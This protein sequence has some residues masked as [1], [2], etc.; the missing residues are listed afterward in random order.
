MCEFFLKRKKTK[1]DSVQ[2]TG[3]RQFNTA[4][5][6]HPQNP[7]D[8]LDIS[9]HPQSPQHVPHDAHSC[10]SWMRESFK[11]RL[12]SQLE[13]TKKKKKIKNC[14]LAPAA[15]VCVYLC[16]CVLND[17]HKC[18]RATKDCEPDIWS[19]VSPIINR[20]HPTCSKKTMSPW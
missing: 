11:S 4:A 19:G 15:E 6:T 10:L 17:Q 3:P 8:K 2:S 7:P 12:L 1:T 13:V 5:E 14:H 18:S 16:V 20:N 9:V